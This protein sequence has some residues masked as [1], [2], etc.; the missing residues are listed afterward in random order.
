[1]I[2]TFNKTFDGLGNGLVMD[3]AV[4]EVDVNIIEAKT[5]KGIPQHLDENL[6]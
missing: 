4:D 6:L 2:Y 1:L 5:V 3:R